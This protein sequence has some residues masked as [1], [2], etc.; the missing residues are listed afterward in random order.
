[1]EVMNLKTIYLSES[2]YNGYIHAISLLD[3]INVMTLLMNNVG[4]YFIDEFELDDEELFT[5]LEMIENETIEVKSIGEIDLIEIKEDLLS[6]VRNMNSYNNK[7]IE[8]LIENITSESLL[9]AI[10]EMKL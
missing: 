4:S 7:L 3:D 5:L 10:N 6:E 9:S 8:T 1:M 2:N